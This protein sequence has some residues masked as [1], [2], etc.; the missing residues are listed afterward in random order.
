VAL[1]GAFAGAAIGLTYAVD[2]GTTTGQPR[3]PQTG[4]PVGVPKNQ[5]N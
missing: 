5:C 3:Q 4:C 1:L 2:R